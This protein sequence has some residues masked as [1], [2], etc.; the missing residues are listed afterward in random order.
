MT[1]GNTPKSSHTS[2]V[3]DGQLFLAS[4]KPQPRNTDDIIADWIRWQDRIFI[5]G[6]NIKTI[7][8]SDNLGV[9]DEA[10]IQ[11]SKMTL[12][13]L[14]EKHLLDEAEDKYKEKLTDF[15]IN[16]INQVNLIHPLYYSICSHVNTSN[17]YT[18]P[19]KNLQDAII[20]LSIQ[21]NKLIIHEQEIIKHL[22][23]LNKETHEIEPYK[24]SPDKILAINNT[25]YTVTF[26]SE[27]KPEIESCVA[28]VTCQDKQILNIF[29]KKQRLMQ[30][31]DNFIRQNPAEEKKHFHVLTNEYPEINNEIQLSPKPKFFPKFFSKTI[32]QSEISEKIMKHLRLEYPDYAKELFDNIKQYTQ[33]EKTFSRA[34]HVLT[35]LKHPDLANKALE[36]YLGNKPPTSKI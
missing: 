35:I 18:L 8:Q 25:Q 14:L 16:N 20:N 17:T 33:N 13:S 4:H 11:E 12:K 15:L 19:A 2:L 29:L 26:N 9:F 32:N 1:H 21:R 30:Y 3:I 22:L 24:D 28:S 7:I 34:L 6:K 5:H 10:H 36:E 23:V 27:K 31:I